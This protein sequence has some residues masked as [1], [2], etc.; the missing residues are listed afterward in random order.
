MNIEIIML[1][2]LVIVLLIFLLPR[3]E[4]DGKERAGKEGEILAGKMIQQYLNEQ[5]ILFNNAEI[6]VHGRETELDYVVINKNGVF[7]FE[8]KNYSGELEGNE[9]DE[10]WNKYKIS[11]GNNEYVKEVRNPI[12]QLKREIYLLKEYLKYYGIDL[13]INGYV[14]FVNMN[15]PIDSD[16]TINNERELNS[17]LHTRGGQTL[18]KKQIE[19][20]V[21]ILK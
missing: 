5:D 4:E 7:I 10:Y 9:D 13:W 14:L 8:V 18:N 3:T 19:K 11:S 2:L 17:I 21:N 16:Y 20:I 15:S 1:F 6:V 12:K